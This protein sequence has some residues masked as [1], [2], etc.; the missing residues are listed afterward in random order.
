MP[1]TG[2]P[3]Q[4]TN[5]PQGYPPSN[6][7]PQGYPPT[8]STP[9]AYPQPQSNS[10]NPQY[11]PHSPQANNNNNINNNNIN[12]NNGVVSPTS[13]VQGSDAVRMYFAEATRASAKPGYM[14]AAECHFF[15]RFGL[16]DTQLVTV[17][18]AMASSFL[19]FFLFSVLIWFLVLFW[20]CFGFRVFVSRFV[21]TTRSGPLRRKA[22][23]TSPTS[24]SKWRSTSSL[25][26]S[27]ATRRS[28]LNC[29]NLRS[30]TK[31][32]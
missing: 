3:P 18:D 31:C 4:P 32:S 21:L 15:R 22:C 24:N 30:S 12:N 25:S 5:N 26:S 11:A 17:R 13:P 29:Y 1:Q 7:T 28:H 27:R 10:N 8:N 14:T 19:S 6:S 9:Q 20:F 2:Y 23:P 16:Q